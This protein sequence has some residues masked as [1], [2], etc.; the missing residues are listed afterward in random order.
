M[1]LLRR[2]SHSAGDGDF[3][4]ID[5][6]V[7]KL[8]WQWAEHTA[9]RKDVNVHPTGPEVSAALVDPQRDG[10]STLS[11]EFGTPYKRP[12]PS[13]GRLSVDMMMMMMMN[14]I[15]IILCLLCSEAKAI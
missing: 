12:M 9:R 14:R 10:L 13:C 11:V 1:G 8:K 4:D 2:L 7:A 5:K 15:L 6:R 3:T